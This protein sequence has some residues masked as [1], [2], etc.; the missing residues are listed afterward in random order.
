MGSIPPYGYQIYK[1]QG[2][3]GNSLKVIP[4]EAKIVKM[5]YNMYGQ[6]GI[7]YNTIAYQL[8][9]M[10]IPSQTGTWGQTSVTNILNNEVYLG[11]FAGDGSYKTYYKR[12][13]AFQEKSVEPGL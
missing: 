1:L 13:N 7:G 5:I 4:E 9:H 6:Q 12:W 11:K 2:E 3:K 10:Q 8:N